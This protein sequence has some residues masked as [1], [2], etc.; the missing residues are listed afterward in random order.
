MPEMIL[1]NFDYMLPSLC[2]C[3]I[4]MIHICEAISL[5]ELCNRTVH[6]SNFPLA[7]L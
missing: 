5:I 2:T 3:V 4:S 6:S 1:T 7:N